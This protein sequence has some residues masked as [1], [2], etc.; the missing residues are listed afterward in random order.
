LDLEERAKRPGAHTFEK[1]LGEDPAAKEDKPQDYT[2]VLK[3]LKKAEPKLKDALRLYH[4]AKI[5]M[6]LGSAKAELRRLSV[7]R[8]A[9][10]RATYFAGKGGFKSEAQASAARKYM[11]T[12][13]VLDAVGPA[14]LEL[15]ALTVQILQE[16]RTEAA[17][18]KRRQELLQQVDN[19]VRWLAQA[20]WQGEPKVGIDGWLKGT[21]EL[22]QELRAH[23]KVHEDL[24]PSLRGAVETLTAHEMKLKELLEAVEETLD[25]L[26]TV[27]AREIPVIIRRDGVEYDEIEIKLDDYTD[28]RGQRGTALILEIS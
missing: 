3:V 24:I 16:R 27:K 26:H 28:S 2:H 6:T 14:L 25:T 12:H 22:R 15:A 1:F 10:A 8:S 9:E 5:G 11:M 18:A 4:E 13:T 23:F 19:A 17:K 21:E 7:L 20:Y